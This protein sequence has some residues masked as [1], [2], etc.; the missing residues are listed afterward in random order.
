MIATNPIIYCALNKDVSLVDV[1]NHILTCAQRENR[2]LHITDK[3]PTFNKNMYRQNYID[4]QGLNDQD[5]ELHYIENGINE[6]RICD[7]II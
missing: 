3:Y 5:L 4:L 7:R 6:C 2:P 1:Y